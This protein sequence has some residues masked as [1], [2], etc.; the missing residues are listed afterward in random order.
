MPFLSLM[1]ASACATTTPVELINAR[2]VFARASGGPAAQY[3]PADLHKAQVA[4]QDAEQSFAQEKGTAKTVDL[5]Y[6]A[7]CTAEIAEAHAQ[8]AISEKREA[9]AKQDFGDTEGAMVKQ[10]QG[11]LVTTR[12]QLADAE[13]GQAEQTQQSAADRAARDDAEMKAKAAEQKATESDQKATAANDALAKLAAKEDE[14]GTVITL[15]GSVLFRSNDAILAPTS[16]SRL[17]QVA[18]AL[19]AKGQNVVVEGHTDSRGSNATNLNLSQRRAESVRS[20][21]VSKGVPTDKIVAEGMGADHPIAENNT[22]EG[23]ANNR[24]VEIV[25]AKSAAAFNRP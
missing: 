14:R 10:A 21:L 15:S 2:A 25:I 22:A 8:S 19:V 7:Q 16:L 24:R 6:I 23:R 12:A 18:D 4:L 11:K 20:Y 9:K 1:V 13:R 17:D 5:A 3:E